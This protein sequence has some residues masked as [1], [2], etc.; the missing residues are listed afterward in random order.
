MFILKM[1]DNQAGLLL[2]AVFSRCLV[3]LLGVAFFGSQYF[4][5]ISS[6]QG[7]DCKNNRITF[8][9]AAGMGHASI[10]IIEPGEPTLEEELCDETENDS[11]HHIVWCDLFHVFSYE[12]LSDTNPLKSLFEHLTLS[13]QSSSTASLVVLHHSWKS[14]L[15]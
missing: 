9:S 12:T 5:F 8:V 6:N 4:S 11:D 3:L 7:G 10:R 13:I 15:V 14:F 2:K 1:F